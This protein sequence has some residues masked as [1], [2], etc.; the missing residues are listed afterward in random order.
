MLGQQIVREL[1]KGDHSRRLYHRKLLAKEPHMN[2]E[3]LWRPSLQVSRSTTSLVEV[4]EMS[5]LRADGH[6]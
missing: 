5:V 6:E 3:V 2:V 1:T 4:R